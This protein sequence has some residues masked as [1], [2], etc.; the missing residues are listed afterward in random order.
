MLGQRFQ[1][2][3]LGLILTKYALKVTAQRLCLPVNSAERICSPAQTGHGVGLLGSEGDFEDPS[4]A[5]G[6]GYGLCPRR[7][8]GIML[9]VSL[10]L[11]HPQSLWNQADASSLVKGPERLTS[12]SLQ[13]TFT[14]MFLL[15]CRKP[16]K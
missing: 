1:F 13:G 5:A 16:L 12:P 15:V 6:W 3:W 10:N 8:D 9:L 14:P 4:H 2:N 7:R 11:F